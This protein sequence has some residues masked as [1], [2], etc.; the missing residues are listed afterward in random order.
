M[1]SSCVSLAADIRKHLLLSECQHPHMLRLLTLSVI[2]IAILHTE[3]TREIF[4]LHEC[5]MVRS[6][7]QVGLVEACIQRPHRQLSSVSNL[8][9]LCEEFVASFMHSALKAAKG[10]RICRAL[11]THL[12]LWGPFQRHS[13]AAVLRES[14]HALYF[15][16]I[17]EI[18]DDLVAPMSQRL[19]LQSPRNPSH[20]YW[21]K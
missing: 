14:W 9:R 15:Q 21:E 2:L 17:F 12:K 8:F 10:I 13:Q 1:L 3:K 18:L 20:S 6:L 19:E 11:C 5:R 4:A 7:S 16:D